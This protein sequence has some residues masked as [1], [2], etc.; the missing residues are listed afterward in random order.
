MHIRLDEGWKL[1]EFFGTKVKRG[2]L[3]LIGVGDEPSHQEDPRS[4]QGYDG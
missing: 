4:W 1:V 3:G 2:F